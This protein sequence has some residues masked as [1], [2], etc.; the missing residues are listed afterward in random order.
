MDVPTAGSV[1]IVN[2]LKVQALG[3]PGNLWITKEIFGP[4]HLATKISEDYRQFFP[5][6]VYPEVAWKPE[7]LCFELV[8]NFDASSCGYIR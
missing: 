4:D 1:E 7:S 2:Q 6:L 5:N 3:A 8:D